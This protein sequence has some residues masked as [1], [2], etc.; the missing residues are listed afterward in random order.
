MCVVG[1]SLKFKLVMVMISIKEG[2]RNNFS[3]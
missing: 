3:K 1:V 2:P